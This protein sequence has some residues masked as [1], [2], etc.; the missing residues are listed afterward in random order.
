MILKKTRLKV[1]RRLQLFAGLTGLIPVLLLTPASVK[2]Q[3]LVSS[4]QMSGTPAAGAYYHPQAITL[5]AP[6]SFSAAANGSL[7][8]YVTG[9]NICSPLA[10]QPS[11]A[12]NYV[13]TYTPTKKNVLNPAADTASSCNVMQNISYFDGLGR[14]L[15]T[16]QVK[17]NPSGTKDVVQPF[18]Y[19]DYGRPVQQFLPYTVSTQTPGAY[20]PGALSN[21]QSDFYNQSGQGYKKIDYPFSQTAFEP[22]PLNRP[23]EQGAPG[24][25]WQL[26][27][28][29]TL[30]TEY[31]TNG[32]NEVKRW[33]VKS[34]GNG[35]E[36]N[37]TYYPAARLVKTT[38]T[39]ENGNHNI[40][41]KDKQGHVVLKQAESNTG[42]LS[43]Y[44]VYDDYEN[45][46]YVIPPLPQGSNPQSFTEQD[47]LFE[48]Y[49][50]GYHYDD[51]NRLTEKK[52]PGKGWE[53]MVYNTLD[54]VVMTQDANQ[55]N[56]SPQQWTFTKYDA[57]G[58][59]VM[60]G[61][62]LDGNRTATT[63]V[64]NGGRQ[65]LQGYYNGTG[66]DKWETRNNSTSTGYS[67]S[68][69]PGGTGY[70]Y[71]T[72]NYYDDYTF[73]GA[74]ALSPD[75]NLG[76]SSDATGLLT[77]SKV[78]VLGDTRMLLSVNYYDDK[79]RVLQSKSQNHLQGVEIMTNA[80][81]E[82]TGQL[83]SSVRRHSSVPDNQANENNS[84][85]ISNT[86]EY[87]HMGRKTKTWQKMGP[88]SDPT[89]LSALEYN[90]VGQLKSKALGGGQQTTQYSYN[91]RGWMKT[92]S[93]SLF[94][95]ELRYQDAL[96]GAPAQWNGNITNQVFT[97]SSSNTFSYSYDKLNRLTNG[98]A[99]GMSEA[100]SYDELGNI[101]SLNRDGQSGTYD[102]EGN[103]LKQ[104][105]NGG[106]A[107]NLYAYDVNGNMTHDGRT[108][109]DFSY[110]V[111]N[112]PQSITGG[113]TNVSYL[114]D[115]AGRKLRKVSDGSATDYVSG[116]Q[117]KSDGTI[118]FVQTEEGQARRTGSSYAY[119]YDL[120]DHLGDVRTTFYRN[121][122]SGNVTAV[123]RDDYYAFGLR[124][125]GAV[126]GDNKYLYNG[127]ELQD[128]T[129]QYDY[130]A[131]FYDPIIARWTSIDPLAEISRRWSPYVYG[132]NSPMNF[133]DP[134]GMT[135]EALLDQ[136]QNEH[137]QHA[138][139]D[140]AALNNQPKPKTQQKKEEEKKRLDAQ[141]RN[142]RGGPIGANMTA[143]ER[144]EYFKESGWT[145]AGWLAGEGVGYMLKPVF[146]PVATWL[147]SLFATSSEAVVLIGGSTGR[148]YTS[149]Q[150]AEL[151]TVR[152]GDL[153]K[154]VYRGMTGSES[155]SGALFLA[156]DAAY[157]ASY[158]KNGYKGATAFKIPENNFRFMISEGMISRAT[159][160]HISA[161]TANSGAEYI[162]SNQ[163]VKQMLLKSLKP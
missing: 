97:N 7:H 73:P 92:L 149:T 76:Q 30:R 3:T 109:K 147:G 10:G 140:V 75:G 111:L 71:Y 129:G 25:D 42:Y 19:D 62:W 102:Y 79:G 155:G 103:R 105:L 38:L 68:S 84:V 40:E 77:G 133:V 57:Q 44:Y 1:T 83:L 159:G 96:N 127:K 35:S 124:K 131:R 21:E 151:L 134:D 64:D 118:D 157:A 141:I 59:V 56:K 137:L 98:S 153:V 89:L 120:K 115:A 55:R 23:V 66:E 122:N 104:I 6:F 9:G 11:N 27:S 15:Q 51:R 80:Y 29:H 18:A 14:Q 126:G 125:T 138:G 163:V 43:T 48:Q 70:T 116:I 20:R 146:K 16:V 49:M 37:N 2:A 81:N 34:G 22:S 114:Y 69:T 143:E 72:I 99:S 93:S 78:N 142:I 123:Q 95:L 36:W 91:E 87:D 28:G 100:I 101:S 85:T 53:Y 132:K 160:V 121:P 162:I 74:S 58:R 130:G 113:G 82:I 60:T 8:I 90:E 12:Q 144:A 54:Q 139:F 32:A 39:D 156:D 67:N 145:A 106:L 45:L 50:Y 107:T 47:A 108:S 135:D 5:Q 52:L 112:L 110:N 152:E 94:N 161:S 31:S 119:Y 128:E 46:S 150:I 33:Q 17:G 61:I 136:W 154:V 65:W 24:P 13:V 41:Y 86:Y 88:A 26:G 117:Y 63:A 4:G 158:A 148:S